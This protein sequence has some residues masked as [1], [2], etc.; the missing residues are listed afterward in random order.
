MLI[1]RCKLKFLNK[2]QL[3]SLRDNEIKKIFLNIRAKIKE[4]EGEKSNS[5]SRKA[6]P[7]KQMQIYYCYVYR[8]LEHRKIV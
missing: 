8:E 4:S 1:G 6:A 7:L 3:Q 5:Q 2:D